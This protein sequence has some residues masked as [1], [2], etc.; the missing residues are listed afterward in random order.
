MKASPIRRGSPR[1]GR[2][3]GAGSTLAATST[4]SLTLSL[5]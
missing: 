4:V 3:A 1:E 5:A 2:P